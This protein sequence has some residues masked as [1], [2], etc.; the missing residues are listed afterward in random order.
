MGV[1]SGLRRHHVLWE[2]RLHRERHSENFRRIVAA[3]CLKFR[4]SLGDSAAECDAFVVIP[5]HVHAI[6]ILRKDNVIGVSAVGAGCEICL[7]VVSPNS[8][9][10]GLKPPYVWRDVFAE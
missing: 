10:A 7:R 5:N 9:R 8:I 2:I 6:I 1:D 3:D 4:K